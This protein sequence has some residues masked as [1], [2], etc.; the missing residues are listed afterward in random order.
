MQ[1]IDGDPKTCKT[2]KSAKYGRRLKWTK[3]LTEIL[4]FKQA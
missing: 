4:I 2:M 1:N 3:N